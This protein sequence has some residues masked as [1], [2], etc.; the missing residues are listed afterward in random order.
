MSVILK[1]YQLFGNKQDKR[2]RHVTDCLV[3]MY[4]SWKIDALQQLWKGYGVFDL[5]SLFFNSRRNI[6]VNSKLCK[7]STLQTYRVWRQSVK[8]GKDT[9]TRNSGR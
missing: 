5:A 9:N 8:G 6:L 3:K 4:D 7:M 2:N 1:L